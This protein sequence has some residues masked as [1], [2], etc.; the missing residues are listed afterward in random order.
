VDADGKIYK[1]SELE[2]AAEPNQ[3]WSLQGV[4][5]GIAGNFSAAAPSLSQLD[6]AGRLCAWL[7]QNLNL[8]PESIVGLGQLTKTESPGKT[9]YSGP[10]WQDLLQRQVQLHLAVLQSGAEQVRDTE[11]TE[12]IERLL[13]EREALR[14]QLDEESEQRQSLQDFT[15][16][17]QTEAAELRQQLLAQSQLPD[18]RP[19]MRDMIGQLPR[20]PGRYVLRSADDVRYIVINHTDTSPGLR[21]HRLA[22]S[23]MPDW[24]GILFDF[25]IDD[26][27]TIFQTQPL[28]EVAETELP[29]IAQAINIAF[30]GTFDERA[31]SREQ[32][33]AGGQ[34]IAWLLT[35]FP[36][37]DIDSVKGLGEF[38]SH[39]SPGRLWLEGEAWK[40]LLVAAVRRASGLIDPSAV[41]SDLRTQL[42]ETG[43]EL[44][45]ALHNGQV[46]EQQ[47]RRLQSE[48]QEL[49]TELMAQT[50]R[51]WGYVVPRPAIRDL[52]SQLPRHPTLRYERRA[53]NQITHVAIHHTATLSTVGPARIAEMHI[54]EDAS[55]GKDAWPGVGYHFFVHAD[56]TID[57]L[58]DLE[59]VS[60]HVYLHNSYAVGIVFA[61]SFM[62]GKVP[63][64]AQVRSGSHLSAWLMQ[65]L[66]IP[67]ARVWGHR[68]YPDNLTVCPGSEWRSGRKWRELLFDGIERVQNGTDIKSMRHYMLFWERSYPGP[69]ARQDFVN[70][71]SYVGRFR[72]TIGFSADDARNAEYVTV[73]GSEA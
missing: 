6:A 34:L 70:A 16:R 26:R 45:L 39:G 47:R 5:I 41:E 53:L 1:V 9:F 52:T 66:E 31:P 14:K 12:Q 20:D 40:V 23:H 32:I 7:A 29:Y 58:N 59:T 24:P 46:L 57:Q 38:I 65:E 22:E 73:V 56:G 49:Q 54:A 62:N 21:L 43:R 8:R 35:R 11:S 67:L 25:C 55:R 19:L 2:T 4:N 3:L 72:P 27:G 33:Y 17:L 13:E 69:M 63:T 51:S 42:E 48:N 60:F 44:Q 18:D 10:R 71:I 36:L 64:S 61:G 30:S 50:D 28:D 68:E 37:L 15:D